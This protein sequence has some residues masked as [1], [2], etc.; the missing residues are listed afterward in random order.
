M[1]TVPHNSRGAAEQ[2][3]H[4]PHWAEEGEYS[5]ALCCL[6]KCKQGLAIG[7]LQKT[8]ARIFQLDGKAEN[9]GLNLANNLPFNFFC[10]RPG[11][12]GLSLAAKNELQWAREIAVAHCQ[13]ISMAVVNRLHKGKCSFCVS[14]AHE[15]DVGSRRETRTALLFSVSQI[16]TRYLRFVKSRRR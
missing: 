10:T 13:A 5:P 16:L 2:M 4:I 9:Q 11:D 12:F 3:Q 7:S 14:F 15:Q 8:Q 1:Q 6:D